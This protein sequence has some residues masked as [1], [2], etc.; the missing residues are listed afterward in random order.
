MALLGNILKPGCFSWLT[1]WR[2][3]GQKISHSFF[4]FLAIKIHAKCSVSKEVSFVKTSSFLELQSFSEKGQQKTRSPDFY[5][6]TNHTEV[7]F[8]L[9]Y[10]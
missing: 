7:Y 2:W 9:G 6:S 5:L 1:F 3:R 4:F 8:S 10:V